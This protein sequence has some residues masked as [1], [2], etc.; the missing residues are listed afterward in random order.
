MRWTN[1]R[2]RTMPFTKLPSAEVPGSHHN[3]QSRDWRRRSQQTSQDRRR[4]IN[5]GAEDPSDAHKPQPTR[6]GT[7]RRVNTTARGNP[8]R[9]TKTSRTR[10][11]RHE[12]ATGPSCVL[13]NKTRARPTCG[14]AESDW[15]PDS[16]GAAP[17]CNEL[18]RASRPFRIGGRRCTSCKAS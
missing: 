4:A 14:A 18:Q 1:R 7:A 16:D 5:L 17:L 13:T 10:T 12:T 15:A 3:H 2:T 9:S 8:R 11:W 6:R